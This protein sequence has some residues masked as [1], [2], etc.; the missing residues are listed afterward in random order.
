MF[1]KQLLSNAIKLPVRFMFE[2]CREAVEEML[3]CFLN[4]RNGKMSTPKRQIHIIC[5]IIT[6]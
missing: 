2:K 5:H 4:K 3:S 6:I 1:F